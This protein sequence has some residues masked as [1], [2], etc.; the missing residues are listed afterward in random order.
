VQELILAR[1]LSEDKLAFKDVWDRPF[2]ARE[3]V[4]WTLDRALRGQPVFA[5]VLFSGCADEDQEC[6][7][8]ASLEIYRP[9]GTPVATVP[10]ILLW[11][12][13][14]PPATHLQ[15]SEQSLEIGFDDQEPLG[16]FQIQCQVCE[17][18]QN[19]CVQLSLPLEL[20]DSSS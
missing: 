5:F 9:D 3:P 17:R 13:P 12:G 4:V 11:R 7:I 19:R 16:V 2:T 14:A 10:D 18:N 20:V 8:D 6:T 1:T 15:M